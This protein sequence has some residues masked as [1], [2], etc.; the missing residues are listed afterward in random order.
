MP[1]AGLQADLAR[2]WGSTPAPKIDPAEAAPQSPALD[3]RSSPA[4]LPPLPTPLVPLPP[5]A[6]GSGPL[7]KPCRCGSTQYAE[8]PIGEGRTRRDCH[9]C[10]RFVGFGRWYDQ[11]GPTP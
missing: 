2:L 10:G 1:A 8:L 7:E 11:G 3:G 6:V 4:V 9:Q 5:G